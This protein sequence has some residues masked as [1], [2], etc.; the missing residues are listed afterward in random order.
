M[1][2]TI[3]QSEF[4]LKQ[5]EISTGFYF[6]DS[7]WKNDLCDSVSYGEQIKIMFP[8][9]TVNS[10]DEELFSTFTFKYEDHSNLGCDFEEIFD[11]LAE[12]IDFITT[13]QIK[14][15]LNACMEAQRENDRKVLLQEKEDVKKQFDRIFYDH[16]HS[17]LLTH[18]MLKQIR[19]TADNLIKNDF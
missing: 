5:L 15:T 13:P 9:S 17:T 11:S 16:F 3:E 14:R 18:D 12:L 7:S 8:N 4:I 6:E 2:H 19:D 10:E 1:I